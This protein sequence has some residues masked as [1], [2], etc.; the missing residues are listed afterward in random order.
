M[1]GASDRSFKISVGDGVGSSLNV[2]AVMAELPRKA[3]ITTTRIVI[4]LSA[5]VKRVFRR[6]YVSTTV[7]ASRC[8]IYK[9]VVRCGKR[10]RPCPV[11]FHPRNRGG[12][13]R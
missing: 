13:R 6:V 2:R 9:H 10:G 3:P 1:T 11:D 4:N 5:F 12:G 8:C 7:S